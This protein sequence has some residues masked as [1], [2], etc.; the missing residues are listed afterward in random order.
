MNICGSLGTGFWVEKKENIGSGGGEGREQGTS[1]L[2]FSYVSS[3]RHLLAIFSSF[4]PNAEPV[5]ML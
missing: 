2:Y 3:A 4:R 5:H 1:H